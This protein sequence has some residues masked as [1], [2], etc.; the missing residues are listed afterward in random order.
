MF[1][2]YM[3]N[4][5]G[6]NFYPYPNTYD[7]N[8]RNTGC[9]NQ[10]DNYE[11]YDYSDRNIEKLYPDI[12]KIVYPMVQKAC[13]K[14]VRPVDEDLIEEL[15][16]D[17]YNNIEAG[18]IINV[19]INVDNDNTVNKVNSRTN[20]SYHNKVVESVENRL[21]EDRQIR[22]T[23]LS[24]LIRILLIRELFGRPGNRPPMPRPPRPPFPGPRS[25]TSISLG[26][27]SFSS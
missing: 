16:K 21:A 1:E 11:Q 25:K 15:T 24:D 26:K 20:S 13:S 14:V 18:D 12:Y 27:T 3:Q 8:F 22:N 2:D 4:L 19:N 6:T 5:L 10:A 9:C 17:V 23:L 7:V